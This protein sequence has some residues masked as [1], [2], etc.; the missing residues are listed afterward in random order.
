MNDAV[1]KYIVKILTYIYII[2]VNKTFRLGTGFL[3]DWT[4]GFYVSSH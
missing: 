4:Y 1:S 2:S 3:Y